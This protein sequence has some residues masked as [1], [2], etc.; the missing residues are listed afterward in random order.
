[1]LVSPKDETPLR[2]KVSNGDLPDSFAARGAHQ[3]GGR[4]GVKPG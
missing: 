4:C 2:G 3:L 1:L